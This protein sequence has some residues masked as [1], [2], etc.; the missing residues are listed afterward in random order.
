[1]NRRFHAVIPALCTSA[2]LVAAAAGQPVARKVLIVGI[3]GFR[4]DCLIPAN[5]PNLD[6]LRAAGASS[7]VCQAE[8][9]T[10]SGPGV[11][12]ASARACIGASTWSQTI[13]SRRRT[14]WIIRISSLA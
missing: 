6:A 4:G 10:V 8:D 9:I 7:L 3:D 13:R 1:M 5:A 11:G 12:R 2:F 14:M